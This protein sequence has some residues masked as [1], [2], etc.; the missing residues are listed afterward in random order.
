MN[1]V[2]SKGSTTGHGAHFW[3]FSLPVHPVPEPV[4]GTIMEDTATES[5][6]FGSFRQVQ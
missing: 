4:E 5:G 1:P 3:Q 6:G 2:V